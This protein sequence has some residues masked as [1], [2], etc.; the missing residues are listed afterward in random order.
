MLLSHHV[1]FLYP[2]TKIILSAANPEP[3]NHKKDMHVFDKALLIHDF[4]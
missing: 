4:G 2:H 3:D 1:N